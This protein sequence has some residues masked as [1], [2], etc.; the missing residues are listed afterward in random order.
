ME[1]WSPN[2][3]LLSIQNILIRDGWSIKDALENQAM[4]V[5]PSWFVGLADTMLCFTLNNVPAH[6]SLAIFVG[7]AETLATLLMHTE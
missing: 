4:A 5:Y 2:N 1:N 6:D 3:G 7:A